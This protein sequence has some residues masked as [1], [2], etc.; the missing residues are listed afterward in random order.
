M[1]RCQRLAGGLGG[2]GTLMRHDGGRALGVTGGWLEGR[3]LLTPARPTLG[4]AGAQAVSTS[5][6]AGLCLAF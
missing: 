6:W 1:H 3:P 2:C 4:E 5:R